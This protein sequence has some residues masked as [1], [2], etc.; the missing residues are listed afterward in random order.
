M[1]IEEDFGGETTTSG[2]DIRSF[3][4]LQHCSQFI[5][6]RSKYN[7]A[8]GTIFVPIQIKSA[9]AAAR[10]GEMEA[11]VQAAHSQGFSAA[12]RGMGLTPSAVSKL[13]GRL[14]Q[15]LSVR[16]FNR[17]TRQLHLTPEGETFLAR[18]EQ[19]LADIADAEA[20]IA[21]TASQPRGLLRMHSNVA[22]AHYQL[23]AAM[24]DF[25]ARYPE[26]QVELSISDTLVD[27]IDAGGDLG[28][29]SGPLPDSTL[30]ARR[31]GSMARVIC[32][33]PAYLRQFGTPTRPRDLFEH[34]C[35][36]MTTNPALR[37]WT[38]REPNEYEQATAGTITLE[39]HGKYSANNAEMLM[40]WALA[41][42]GI[43][44]IPDLMAGPAI[45]AGELIPLLTAYHVAEPIPL[46]AVC[47]PGR[48]NT[49][50]VQA[51]MSYLAERFGDS[52]WR[53]K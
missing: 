7:T 32:A 10:T 53:L 44:R 48:Q 2:E 30:V 25:S 4:S 36:A 34:N 9:S 28:V 46:W 43:A 52:P 42:S 5:L 15:R 13:V 14:E 3:A 16:L 33:S 6:I 50:R 20:E 41:G 22:F 17:T 12:A 45:R 11:F 35:M 51:M 49:P 27:L 19:I 40:Q 8:N 23:P 47:P 38:F 24:R 26:V 37:R 31:I 18:A 21:E 29:R 1:F 39:L